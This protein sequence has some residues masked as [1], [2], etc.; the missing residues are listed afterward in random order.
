MLRMR[1][2]RTP[3]IGKQR[4]GKG[5]ESGQS[6]VEF[7]LALPLMVVLLAG[8]CDM[9][10]IVLHK[11]RLDNLA[12]TLSYVNQD[13]AIETANANAE[14]YTETNYPSY[15]DTSTGKFTI[16]VTTRTNR[17]DYF[18]YI[19]QPLKGNIYYRVPMYNVTLLTTVNLEYKVPYL[20]GFGKFIFGTEDNEFT[21]KA[22]ASGYRLLENEAR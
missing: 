21:I 5:G 18:D 14:R 15:P 7:A 20:T 4:I 22:K 6:M 12:Y 19:W 2:S 9:G 8:F 16:N 10:W 13:F 3:K 17:I 1:K 11:I